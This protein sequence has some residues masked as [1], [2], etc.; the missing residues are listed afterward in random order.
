MIMK[1]KLNRETIAMRI[2][3]EI[4]NNSYVNLGIGIPTLVSQFTSPEQNII[5]HSE[6]GV[7]NYG[8]LAEVGEED[9]D[10]INAGGQFLKPTIGMS[11]FNSADAFAMIRGGHIDI[12][13]LG[14]L[15]ISVKGDLA[16][17]MIPERGIGNIGGAMDLATGAKKLIV[18]MEHTDRN[19]NPKIVT[20]C[21]YPLT[22]PECVDLIVTDLC[23]ISVESQR[24][25]V[26]EIAPGW[27]KDEIQNLTEAKLLFDNNITEITL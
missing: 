19:N 26:K 24:L 22:V 18:A 15:Q 20:K 10:L 7:L 17:W 21:S 2:A 14:A 3:K 23:V 6:N 9:P 1:E 4:P 27:N 8:S 13:V 12:S 11:F 25:I 5:F 16:N